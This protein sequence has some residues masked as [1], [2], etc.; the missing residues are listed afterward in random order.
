M[1]I[2]DMYDIQK[3]TIDLEVALQIDGMD[4]AE[5]NVDIIMDNIHKRIMR[6]Y[7]LDLRNTKIDDDS[8]YVGSS[9]SSAVMFVENMSV[10]HGRLAGYFHIVRFTHQVLVRAVN[11]NYMGFTGDTLK[12]VW[13]ALMNKSTQPNAASAMKALKNKFSYV[14]NCLEKKLILIM[15]VAWELGFYEL[16]AS[17]AEIFYIGQ[18]V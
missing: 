17:I 10:L 16:V 18:K 15:L 12:S 11:I 1:N 3:I 2:T 7:Q 4:Y 6:Q 9:R 14:N 5:K 8:L 13:I